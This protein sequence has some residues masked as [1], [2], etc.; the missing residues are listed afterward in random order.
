MSFDELGHRTNV[1]YVVRN[2][3]FNKA[4]NHTQWKDIG[5][6]GSSVFTL[7]T[8]YWPGYT[9]FGPVENVSPRYRVVTRPA[10]PFVFINGPV[11]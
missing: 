9:I 5:F 4:D 10:E 2:K 6:V 11:V 7:N 1:S 8:I 3:E